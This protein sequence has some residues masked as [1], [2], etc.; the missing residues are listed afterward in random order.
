MTRH[1]AACDGFSLVEVMVAV[2]LLALC[3]LPLA[4]AVKNGLDAAGIGEAKALELGCM[5]NMMETVLAEPFDTLW[6][7]AHGNAVPS[8]YSQPAAN[9]CGIRQVFIA[10]YQHKINAAAQVLPDNDPTEDTLLLV[11]VSSP[12][13]GYT[14]AT[15]VDR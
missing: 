14:F 3:A 7:A 6:D 1:R 2:A 9:G 13:S 5:K 4:D 8:V 11:T 12:A 15:L 10:K